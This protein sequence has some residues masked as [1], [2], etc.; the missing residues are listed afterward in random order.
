L[1]LPIGSNEGPYDVV[2]LNPSGVE[3]F[4]TNATAKLE[5][6]VVVL[7]TAVDIAGVPP[8]GYLLGIRQSGPDWTRFPVRLF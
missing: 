7:R 6:H 1:E 3:L 8:G 5:D 2:L 4:R